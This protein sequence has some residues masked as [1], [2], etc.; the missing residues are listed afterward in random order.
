MKKMGFKHKD[1]YIQVHVP[2]FITR[3]AD[4]GRNQRHELVYANL[5]DIDSRVQSM[6]AQFHHARKAS[7]VIFF[8]SE[9]ERIGEKLTDTTS[10]SVHPSGAYK[11]ASL[12][13]DETFVSGVISSLK[14]LERQESG[15]IFFAWDGQV[16]EK[17]FWAIDA[18][19]NTPMLPEWTPYLYDVLLRDKHMIP[20]DVHDA[21]GDYPDLQ[22]FELLVDEDVLDP[23]IEDGIRSGHIS[24]PEPTKETV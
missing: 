17:F 7:D 5:I 3:K 2:L 12:R 6:F 14:A 11:H 9:A 16:L 1:L 21:E 23:I 19:Y 8:V 10:F 13:E 24:I 15:Y 4:L 22:A 20:L 18:V